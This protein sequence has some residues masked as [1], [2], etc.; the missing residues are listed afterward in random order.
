M[1]K[2][3]KEFDKFRKRIGGQVSTFDITFFKC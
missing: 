3:N 1:D 2:F